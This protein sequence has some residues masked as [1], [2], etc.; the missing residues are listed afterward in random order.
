MEI[1]VNTLI[2]LAIAIIAILFFIGYRRAEK[3]MRETEK[4]NNWSDNQYYTQAS[5]LCIFHSVVYG[6]LT[7]L[8]LIL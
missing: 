6:A 8:L 1:K 4:L 7:V 2:F 5:T 3:K